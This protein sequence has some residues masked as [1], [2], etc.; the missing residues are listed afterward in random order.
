MLN[1]RKSLRELKERGYPCGLTQIILYIQP[2]RTSRE[3]RA[4]MRYVTRPGEH[5]QLDRG[6][7][8]NI[9][10][11]VRQQTH[12]FRKQCATRAGVEGTISQA[13]A[14]LGTHRSH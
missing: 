13:A 2:Y 5:A 6:R 7:F 10:Q 1:T 14:A 8:G 9:I 11:D 12:D 3:E 4:V